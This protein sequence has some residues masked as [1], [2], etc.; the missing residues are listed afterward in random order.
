MNEQDLFSYPPFHI[1]DLQPSTTIQHPG[2]PAEV[3][4]SAGTSAYSSMAES[5][6]RHAQNPPDNH[7]DYTFLLC[8][9]D[10]LDLGLYVRWNDSWP[11]TIRDLQTKKDAAFGQNCLTDETADGRKFLHYPS[12]KAP[13]YRFHLQF[14]EYNIF[15]ATRQRPSEKA[16]SP[17]VYASLAS[18]ALWQFGIN[19]TIE[20]LTMDLEYFGGEVLK[21][22]PSRVDLCADYLIPAGLSFDFLRSHQVSRSKAVAPIINDNVLE[23]YYCGS[24]SAPV[25]VRI[26]NKSK[27][28]LK[29]G[30]KL[31][32]FPLW[33][34]DQVDNV[35][36]IEFQLRRTLLKQFD[37]NSIPDLWEKLGGVW[38]YLTEEWYSLRVPDNEKAERR[39]IH[40]WWQMIQRR[41]DTL[42]P[43]IQVQ[44]TFT[45]TTPASID[46]L[47]AHINGC[48]T[49]VAARLG[50]SD[51]KEVLTRLEEEISSK[52]TESSFQEG[53][54]KRAIRLGK[55]PDLC[56]VIYEE[57]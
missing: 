35:W 20:L 14:P 40:P 13:N 39:T 56:G 31:W 6:T 17:N 46:W 50:I 21:I 10:S 4:G 33:G 12:G 19:N 48:I 22:Q 55:D 44:R 18:E 25:Q 7:D 30:T 23:T 32:F 37:V 1:D 27:E 3:P 45:G 51:R 8:G 26:Y 43:A 24:K 47:L 2:N 52:Y 28:V 49:S 53:F 41:K 29:K 42:G 36:R 5:V 38:G 11:D 16:P 57:E 34:I 54:V 15:I 9:I